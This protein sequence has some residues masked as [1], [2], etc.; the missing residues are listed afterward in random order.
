LDQIVQIFS[1]F[2]LAVIELW[3]AIPAG[4]ALGLNPVLIGIC[5]ASGAILGTFVVIWVGDRF[6]KWLLRNHSNNNPKKPG[7]V[8][9]I[10]QRYGLIGLGLLAPLLSGAPLG[11]AL[12]ISL[13]AQKAS[14]MFWMSLGIIFWTAILTTLGEFGIQGIQ[15][16]F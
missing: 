13:G 15:N 2:L 12:G 9:R 1:V 11:A 8:Q 10:W 14:L 16:I 5:A 3:S 6:R 7:V 4:L